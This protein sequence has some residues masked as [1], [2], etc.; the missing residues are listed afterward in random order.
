MGKSEE[1]SEIVKVNVWKKG[2]NFTIYAIY[3][4]P[5]N[6]P[7]LTSLH[8]TS[9][10][11]MIRD[12]NAHSPKWSY[13]N[14]NTAGKE[15]EDLLST[16]ILELIYD[17]DP[18]TYV[19]FN[20]AQTTPDIL[21][22]SSDISANT[23]HVILDDPGSGHKPVIAKITL[24]QQ[25]RI[26]SPYIRTS[27]N[28]KKANWK[29]FTDMLEINLHQERMDFSQHPDKISEVINSI[30]INCA[31]A[32]IPRGRVKRYKCFWTDDLETLKNQRENLRKRAEHIGKTE[33]VQAWRRQAAILRKEITESKRK[34][35]KNFICHIDYQK[36]S[37]KTYKYVARIQNNTP[38]SNTV[39][40]HESNVVITSDRGIANTFA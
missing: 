9:K 5:N 30:I 6:K 15:M 21:L 40:I 7:N 2:N 16:S 1:K 38:C 4:P 20:G 28:F 29:S 19:H 24:T 25:Q 10:T 26:L 8:V 3:S 34:S 12:F 14:T 35:F 13:K 31:K 17:T 11:V 36:H 32:C 33:A 18:S 37:H 23:K 39:P 27:W 22:V